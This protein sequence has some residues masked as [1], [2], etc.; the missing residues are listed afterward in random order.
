MSISSQEL[1]LPRPICLVLFLSAGLTPVR[2]FPDPIFLHV[3]VQGWAPEKVADIERF[4]ATNGIDLARI[5]LQVWA[6][7]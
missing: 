3:C 5:M 2:C 4:C 1:L 6:G 7:V